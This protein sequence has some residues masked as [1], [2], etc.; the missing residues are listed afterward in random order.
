ML[1]K[2]VPVVVVAFNRANSLSRLLQS[3]E[4]AVYRKNEVPLIISIDK[5]EN[6]EDV[7]QAAEQFVWSHG[8]KKVVYQ[9][10]NLK[11]RRHVLRCGDYACEYGNVIILEDDLYVSPYFYEYAL[12]ALEFVKTESVVGGVSLYNHRYNVIASEPFEARDDGYDNWYFQFASSW[13]QAWT[14]RQW[15]EFRNWYAKN[16]NIDNLE[17]V[18]LYVRK[19]SAS[20]WLK[21]FIAFLIENNRFFLYPK[22]S[23]T[24]NFG[25]AGTHVNRSN[26]NFQVPLQN[27]PIEYRFTKV[28][29][30][31]SIYDVFFESVTLQESLKEKYSEITID[32]Y[33]T[34]NLK[35]VRSK[36]V[37]TRNML[38]YKYVCSYGCCMRPHEDNI[39]YQIQGQEFFLYDMSKAVKQMTVQNKLQGVQKVQYNLRYVH[40]TQYGD[41]IKLFMFKTLDGLLKRIRRR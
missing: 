31:C 16:P 21:Y 25:E 30:S 37:L 9:S 4:N 11:L 17:S 29:D 6:N 15:L 28:K 13:G 35:N 23:L 24:T 33:G 26:T 40:H 8:E 27:G 22:I 41:V 18:P 10:E 5:G 20:S 2:P 38:P 32:L 7:L 1:S 12:Q 34:K 3:L 14:K 36:F 39:L 19:W